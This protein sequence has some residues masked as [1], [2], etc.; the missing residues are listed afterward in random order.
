MVIAVLDPIGEDVTV[1]KDPL[2]GQYF[3]QYGKKSVKNG[4]TQTAKGELTTN[5]LNIFAS[6]NILKCSP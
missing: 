1:R 4:Q 6:K 5:P 3:R 2:F